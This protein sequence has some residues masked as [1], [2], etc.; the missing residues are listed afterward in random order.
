MVVVIGTAVV[1]WRAWQPGQDLPPLSVL[2]HPFGSKGADG[3][4]AEIA[5][6]VAEGLTA[7][8]LALSGSLVVGPQIAAG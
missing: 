4:D 7:Q 6:V 3:Q 1:G 8:L 2:V 5:D